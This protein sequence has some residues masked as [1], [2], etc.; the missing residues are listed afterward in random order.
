M[1]TFKT[2]SV[3]VL[4]ALLVVWFFQFPWWIGIAVFLVYTGL[5]VWGSIRVD[6]Q[7]YMK[8]VVKGAGGNRRIAI[9]FDD[10]PLPE[11]T[12][13]VLDTL[14]AAKVP[15]SFFC[16][17]KR[18]SQYPELARK[19]VEQG[20][21]IGNHSFSHHA[22]FDLYS[23]GRMQAELEQTNA[24]LLETTGK[25][26]RYFRPPYGVTNPNLAKAVKKTGM[27][28]IGW[29]IRSLDT[30]AKEQ[31]KLLEKLWK[32]LQPGAIVLFHDTM[33][34]TAGLLPEFLE[35]VKKRGFEIVPID[36]LINEDAYA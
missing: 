2:S 12:L 14:S 10:G 32:Q 16:I 30:V 34:I 20:H 11:Y 19:I 33:S 22:L 26:P 23:S 35:G 31:D 18:V 29:N 27:T 7:F 17:G 25:R 21:I 3:L 24:L 13:S 15:A 1:L 36:Q 8:A 9:S 5:L 4:I 28:T 6:S